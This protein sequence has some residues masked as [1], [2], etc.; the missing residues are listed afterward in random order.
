MKL[1]YYLYG[2]FY[3]VFVLI[4]NLLVTI[5]A[6]GHIGSKHNTFVNELSDE[7]LIEEFNSYFGY[8]E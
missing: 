4:I 2:C 6:Y 7:E 3:G 8:H 1:F 5:D